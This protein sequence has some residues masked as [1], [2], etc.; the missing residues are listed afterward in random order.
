MRSK[1]LLIFLHDLDKY[2]HLMNT[3]LKMENLLEKG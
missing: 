1:N 2:K 3:K